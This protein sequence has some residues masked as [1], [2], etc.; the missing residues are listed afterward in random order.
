MVPVGLREDLPNR[1]LETGHDVS[2]GQDIGFGE[3]NDVGWLLV[4]SGRMLAGID[5]D[6]LGTGLE[7]AE[8]LLL[9][10]CIPVAG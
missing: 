7:P 4:H 1:K 5:H 9:D 10:V 2:A 8:D 3:G 6:H